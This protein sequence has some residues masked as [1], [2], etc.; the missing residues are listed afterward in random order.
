MK[1]QR[2]RYLIDTRLQIRYALLFVAI[3]LISN[4]LSVTAFNVLA[5]KQLDTL[6]WST[7]ISINSTD[8]LIRPLFFFVN[9]INF[10]FVAAL[11]VLI[12]FLMLKKTSG[13][14]I[15]MTRDIRKVTGGDL[16]SR[17]VL[18][19]KDDFRDVAD[20]LN[21]MTGELRE[22]FSGL[23]D[24]Y[25]GLSRSLQMIRKGTSKKDSINNYDSI[26]KSIEAVET[27]LN[28]LEL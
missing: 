8:D 25:E 22:R 24:K 9:I 1:L 23:K 17:I 19:Q 3:S 11:L 5:L 27:E 6:M 28:K 16:S 15:R 2:S 10:V 13:P 14:L 20:E 18:R 7:H 26:L 4:I 21:Q 12:G